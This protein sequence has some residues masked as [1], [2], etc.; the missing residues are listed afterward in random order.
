MNGMQENQ[1]RLEPFQRRLKTHKDGTAEL[2]ALT[3]ARYA[4]RV[5][6]VASAIEYT[7]SGTATA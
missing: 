4:A 3:R 5:G 2:E 6:T 7:P 1:A